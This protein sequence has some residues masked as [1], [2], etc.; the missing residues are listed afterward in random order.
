MC[1]V[2]QSGNGDYCIVKAMEMLNDSRPGI[3]TIRLILENASSHGHRGAV[4]LLMFLNTPDVEGSRL[5]KA[6]ST[7]KGFFEC[8]ELMTIR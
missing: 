3:P 2:I 1:R 8:Q 6:F 7:F 5:D 4:F